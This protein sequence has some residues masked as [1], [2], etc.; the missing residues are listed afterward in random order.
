M[1][2]NEIFDNFMF[3][4]VNNCGFSQNGIIADILEVTKTKVK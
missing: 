2:R 3:I 4:W 1:L